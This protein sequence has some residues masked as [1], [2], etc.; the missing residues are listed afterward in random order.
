MHVQQNDLDYSIKHKSYVYPII[1][2]AINTLSIFVTKNTNKEPGVV[3]FGPYIEWSWLATRCVRKLDNRLF[4][5]WC[6]ALC[7]V[8]MK[9]VITSMRAEACAHNSNSVGQGPRCGRWPRS[10][11]TQA[12]RVHIGLGGRYVSTYR[13]VYVHGRDTLCFLR[14]CWDLPSC[15]Q[16]V[17]VF[18][19]DCCCLLILRVRCCYRYVIPT[20]HSE[21]W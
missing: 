5:F 16:I 4:P 11:G 12:P 20:P 10:T 17:F 3:Y 14:F 19:L 7:I 6:S 15:S 2:V 13:R 18:L 8:A 1:I 9:R 21:N